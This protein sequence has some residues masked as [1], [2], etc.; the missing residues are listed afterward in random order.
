MVDSFP[1]EAKA[2]VG[3]MR[4]IAAR[5]NT[6]NGNSFFVMT[7]RFYVKKVIGLIG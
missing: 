4:P 2:V 6:F 3:A 5:K 1:D 7:V